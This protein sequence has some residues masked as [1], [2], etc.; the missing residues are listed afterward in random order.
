M[1]PRLRRLFVAACWLAVAA[2]YIAAILP[3]Q[4]APHLGGSDKTDHMAAF[5]TV[6]LLARFAYPH[7]RTWR[8]FVPIALFGGFIELS[9]MIPAIHRDAEWA[10]WAADM[11]ASAAALLIAW[12]LAR[13]I[14]RPAGEAG[15]SI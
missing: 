13:R 6:S 1:S 2:A 11:I 5:F 7:V 10:D 15:G 3:Q 8:L 14:G 12:P 4:E 9:Q